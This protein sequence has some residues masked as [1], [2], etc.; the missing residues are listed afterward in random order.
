MIFKKFLK[1]KIMEISQYLTPNRPGCLQIG[2]T[3]GGG[4]GVLPPLSNFYLNG[5][6]DLKFGMYT[7][8]FGGEH[9]NV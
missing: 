6:S 9:N 7:V 3:L 2:T 5:P 4:G 1:N 8:I